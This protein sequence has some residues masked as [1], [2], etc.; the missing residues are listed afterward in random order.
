[1]PPAA[2]IDSV[3]PVP[4]LF[5]LAL[6]AGSG[7]FLTRLFQATQPRSS[8]GAGVAL[9]FPLVAVTLTALF[10]T[11]QFSLPLSIGLLAA[12]SLARFRTPVKQPDEAGFLWVVV[13]TCATLAAYKPAFAGA[14]LASAALIAAVSMARRR[15]W[16]RGERR[17]TG[18]LEVMLPREAREDSLSRLPQ[19][20]ARRGCRL[21]SM[22]V[23]A[24]GTRLA[25]RFH[26]PDSAIAELRAELERGGPA[27]RVAVRA[28]REPSP[29]S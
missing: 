6:A 14:M 29:S 20:A 27:T 19:I 26:L 1:M 22:S 18:V 2:Q 28:D 23:G 21:E 9:S 12:L 24:E 3:G 13:A 8:M 16:F 15:P 11:V 5:L 4:V 25:Y 17:S 10:L 7:L